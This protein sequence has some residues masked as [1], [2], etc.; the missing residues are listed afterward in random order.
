MDRVKKIAQKY[1]VSIRI[2]YSDAE[3]TCCGEIW[4]AAK[5]ENIEIKR[6]HDYDTLV[7]YL[8]EHLQNG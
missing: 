2:M 7:D 3:D 6:I 5:S 4:S 8:E 1:G